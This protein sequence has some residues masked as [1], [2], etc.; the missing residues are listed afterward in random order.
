MKSKLILKSLLSWLCDFPH[1]KACLTNSG[2]NISVCFLNT[3]LVC[4]VRNSV[5]ATYLI[6]L[7]PELMCEL[8][9]VYS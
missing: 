9:H 1:G 3:L 5:V 2:D 8:V 6:V 7:L 4:G